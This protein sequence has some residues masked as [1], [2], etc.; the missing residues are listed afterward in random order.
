M[1]IPRLV[2][3]FFYYSLFYMNQD[4]LKLLLWLWTRTLT[5]NLTYKHW[6]QHGT[7]SVIIV[8]FLHC[9][10]TL[11]K[12][13]TL[14]DRYE[15]VVKNNLLSSCKIW[16]HNSQLNETNS[17]LSPNDV[18]GWRPMPWRKGEYPS[19]FYLGCSRYSKGCN[20]CKNMCA[21]LFLT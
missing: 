11:V 8:F 21:I 3:F 18:L 12:L 16:S 9:G 19:T 15:L 2:N 20:V 1:G 7:I 4:F 5:K 6:D 13:F 10:K 17:T 14:R